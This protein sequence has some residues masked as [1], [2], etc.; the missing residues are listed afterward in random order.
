M[1][2]PKLPQPL[3]LT[4]LQKLAKGSAIGHAKEN[5]SMRPTPAGEADDELL[6]VKDVA[7]I[8]RV[9]EKTVRGWIK[10]GELRAIRKG[11]LI[12]ITKR[13]L[14]KFLKRK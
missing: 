9:H 12:R 5:Q 7:R 3:C 1:T 13:A 6:T 2:Q 11:R 14:A 4:T 10:L 8:C